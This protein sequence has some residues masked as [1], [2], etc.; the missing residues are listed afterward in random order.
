MKR[1][2]R[3]RPKRTLLSLAY[4]GNTRTNLIRDYSSSIS[5]K[6]FIGAAVILKH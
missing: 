2:K 6:N 1:F 4:S 3:P 5:S